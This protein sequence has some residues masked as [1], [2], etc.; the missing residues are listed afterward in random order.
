[1]PYL[2]DAVTRKEKYYQ[3]L[4][5]G[6]GVIPDPVTREEQYLYYL[7]KNGGTGGEVTPEQIQQ[8]VDAY[9]E[10]N[11][12][13]PGATVEQADQIEKNKADISSVKED[14][15]SLSEESKYIYNG[16][17]SVKAN[18]GYFV[19]ITD[20]NLV[21]DER[22][23]YSDY[24]HCKSGTIIYEKNVTG[25]E[26]IAFIARYDIEKN[27]IEALESGE[28][29]YTPVNKIAIINE[30][31]YVRLCS[32]KKTGDWYV[33]QN[34]NDVISYIDNNIIPDISKL[35]EAIDKIKKTI[36]ASTINIP[37][38]IDNNGRLVEHGNYMCSDFIPV[39]GYR[40]LQLNEYYATG[41]VICFFD[42]EQSVVSYVNGNGS[43]ELITIHIP[44]NAVYVRLS[45][46]KPNVDRMNAILSMFIVDFVDYVND[47]IEK[48]YTKINNVH[49][50]INQSIEQYLTTEYASISLFETIG[51]CGDSYGSGCSGNTSS[52]ETAPAHYSL[53]WPQVLARRNGINV[54]N[55]TKAG[56]S[57][58]SFILDSKNGLPKLLDHEPRGLYVMALIRNDYNIEN[59][60]EPGYI[61]TINDITEN[62]LG[63]YPDSFY[64]NYATIIEKIQAHAPNSKIV[65]MTGDYVESNELG[66]EYNNAVKEIA[67]H[68]GL[69]VMI[70]LN[71]AFF[72][73]D[74]YRKDWAAGGHPSAIIYSG[75]AVAIERMLIKCIADYK[76]Y[77]TYYI[78]VKED[79][80]INNYV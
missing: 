23:K 67:E 55:Y 69:P 32:R 10:E 8:A 28:P 16:T 50:E 12:V 4:A 42:E 21:Q 44:E 43:G 15:S 60:G 40:E 56:A 47:E 37:G 18:E 35:K 49:S 74:Y 1:M 71:D 2:P 3:Y 25:T 38:Y 61:G 22:Y 53:S 72:R 45:C 63:T 31:C 46:R 52:D 6:T 65:M 68:Y 64:G 33:L 19:K 59:G 36:Q 75:M 17:M 5:T 39:L 9:L 77:F 79:D 29:S 20:G 34:I 30:E 73:S 80:T 54:Y 24:I 48:I 41:A 14:V 51:V 57:T 27:F 7:C 26:N 58:R 13:Q 78:G 76:S 62:S 11:P 70:Q 66:T